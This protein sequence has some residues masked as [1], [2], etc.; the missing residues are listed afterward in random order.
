MLQSLYNTEISEKR[1]IGYCRRHHRYLS[2]TQ[3]KKKQC[4]GKQCTH[5]EKREHEF[6]KQ[7][8]FI[9]NKR[10]Q[11]KMMVKSLGDVYGK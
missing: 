10:E 1:A 9:K 11:R 4:L 6:W 2:S 5:L 8:E 3:L 7:R